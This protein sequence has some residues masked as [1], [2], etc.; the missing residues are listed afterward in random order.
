MQTTRLPQIKGHLGSMK[1]LANHH[2]DVGD[3]RVMVS[4]RHHD[5]QKHAASTPLMLLGFWYFQPCQGVWN[6]GL[7]WAASRVGNQ[8]VVHPINISGNQTVMPRISSS[9]VR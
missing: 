1:Y 2:V 4:T 6:A 5:Q 3:P 8:S 7:V 9:M